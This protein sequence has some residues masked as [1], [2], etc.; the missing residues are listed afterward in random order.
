MTP[1]RIKPAGSLDVDS[2]QALLAA[3]HLPTDGFGEHLRTALVARD[4]AGIIGCV[5]LERYGSLA[6]LRSLAV[7]SSRRGQGVGQQ[8]VLAALDL[9]RQH[10]VA[11][12]YL[13]TTTAADFFAR[14]FGFRP[15]GRA[16]VP[17]PI[18]QSVEF[19][20]ACPQTAQAMVREVGP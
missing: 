11:A 15:I 18:Q 13:L 3:A 20:S 16:E 7:T 6:L 14:R 10:R 2:L 5:A 1:A 12:V 8:L 9:A 17:V 19:T 4:A